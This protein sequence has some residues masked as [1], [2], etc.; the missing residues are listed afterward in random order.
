MAVHIRAMQYDGS[1]SSLCSHLLLSSSVGFACRHTGA[2][3]DA[4]LIFTFVDTA[5]I[6]FSWQTPPIS[7]FQGLMCFAHGRVTSK[8]SRGQGKLG[9]KEK[10]CGLSVRLLKL[11]F[12]VASDVQMHA[13][14]LCSVC[15]ARV[16]KIT[17]PGIASPLADQ[18]LHA[19]G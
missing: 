16:R 5:I 12:R 8:W 10:V 15:A 19:G 14:R 9:R 4:N 1:T 11:A 3:R 6:L 7:Q 18:S 17:G 13:H 2:F